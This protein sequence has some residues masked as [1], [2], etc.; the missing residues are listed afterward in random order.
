MAPLC[1]A[2]EVVREEAVY[3]AAKRWFRANYWSIIAGQPPSGCDHFPVVEIKDPE[4]RELGSRGAFKPD[5]IVIKDRTILVTECKPQH[6]DADAEK[7]RA[8]LQ[9]AA[10]RRLLYEEI[11]QRRLLVKRGIAM[12]YAE[13]DAGLAGVLA[14][15]PPEQPQPDLYVLLVH[16]DDAGRDS[17]LPPRRQVRT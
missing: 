17:L 15:S 6:S 3:I 8:F 2:T 11:T 1:F 7:L 4:K 16:P 14:H 12:T 9:S 10:R 13:F 5:L